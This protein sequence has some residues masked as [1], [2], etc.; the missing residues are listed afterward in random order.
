MKYEYF[1]EDCQEVIEKEFP[2]GK[3]EKT[4]SCEKCG[5][6]AERYLGNVNFVLKGGGWPSRSVRM[7]NE[8]T[9]KNRAAGRKMGKAWGGSA[10]RLIDQG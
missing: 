4:V 5:K 6:E 1:C 2:F 8:Q 9:A 10:P 3:A 7:K